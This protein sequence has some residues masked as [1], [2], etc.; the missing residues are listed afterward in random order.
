MD[1]S[2]AILSAIAQLR[3][4]FGSRS[5]EVVDWWPDDP[6]QIGIARLRAEEP[7]LCI[8]TADKSEGRVDVEYGGKIYGDCV[9]EGLCWFVSEAIRRL[10]KPRAE[11]HPA[12]R[13]RRTQ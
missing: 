6:D 4:R 2:A 5:F 13:V 7:V 11:A 12:R 9:V 3:E 8:I 1:K 10:A